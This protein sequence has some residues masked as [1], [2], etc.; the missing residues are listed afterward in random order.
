MTNVKL[1]TVWFHTLAQT[2]HYRDN[3]AGDADLDLETDFERDLER[4]RA[5]DLLEEKK[6]KHIICKHKLHSQIRT[7]TK[8]LSY[9]PLIAPWTPAS[10][11]APTSAAASWHTPLVAFYLPWQGET[12]SS[13]Q[14]TKLAKIN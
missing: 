12:E 10:T 6:E 2:N 14:K 3:L 1:E 7:Q 5:G 11:T 8:R 9:I 4:E 13:N